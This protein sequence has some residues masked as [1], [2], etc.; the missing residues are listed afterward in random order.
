MDVGK[1]LVGCW[2]VRFPNSLGSQV[3]WGTW[4]GVGH[5]EWGIQLK[6][7][8]SL[9]Q[10]ITQVGLIWQGSCDQTLDHSLTAWLPP[11]WSQWTLNNALLRGMI[12]CVEGKR[13][14]ISDHS[15]AKLSQQLLSYLPTMDMFLHQQNQQSIFAGC[16]VQS[17]IAAISWKKS[18]G[19]LQRVLLSRPWWC[20][21]NWR[22]CNLKVSSR[23]LSI[24]P[25][26]MAVQVLM[27]ACGETRL[28]VLSRPWPSLSPTR[29]HIVHQHIKCMLSAAVFSLLLLE[30]KKYK[31]GHLGTWVRSEMWVAFICVRWI[32]VHELPEFWCVCFQLH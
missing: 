10:W 21:W 13:K 30:V 7:D 8:D 25:I 32:E 16:D 17:H 29:N 3:G 15:P 12:M 4:L 5:H 23:P 11:A 14:L 24:S 20:G 22:M 31:Q 28:K 1:E 9:N 27:D 18:A 26:T 2:L 6:Q 19:S